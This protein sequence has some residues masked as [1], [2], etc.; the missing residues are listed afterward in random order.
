[1]A[2]LCGSYAAPTNSSAQERPHGQQGMD[3]CVGLRVR[4][5]T[6]LIVM[7]VLRLWWEERREMARR[8]KVPPIQIAL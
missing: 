3:R 5:F 2:A 7:A 4:N 8:K 6:V 1:M